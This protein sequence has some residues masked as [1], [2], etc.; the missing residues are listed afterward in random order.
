MA[1]AEQYDDGEEELLLDP[2]VASAT[3]LHEVI[4]EPLSRVAEVGGH[5]RTILELYT[6]G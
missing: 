4:A 5:S 3:G 6:P 1:F 2:L